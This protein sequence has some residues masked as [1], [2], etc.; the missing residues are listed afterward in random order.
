M[1][2]LTAEFYVERSPSLEIPLE[3]IERVVVERNPY[4][5]DSRDVARELMGLPPLRSKEEQSRIAE[6]HFFEVTIVF[7]ADGANLFSSFASANQGR[8]FDV[9]IGGNRLDVLR[10]KG[11]PRERTVIIKPLADEGA[12]LHKVFRLLGK[13]VAWK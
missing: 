8:F 3:Q 6:V 9:R 4:L 11:L 12:R 1:L 7:S 13:R 2:D 5:S 10:I